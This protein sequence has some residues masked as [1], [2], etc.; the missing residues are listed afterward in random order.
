MIVLD[1]SRR[2]SASLAH[3]ICRVD[4][5][6]RDVDVS[7]ELFPREVVGMLLIGRFLGS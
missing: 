7:R 5:E 6:S 1:N 2:P 4:H 3:P